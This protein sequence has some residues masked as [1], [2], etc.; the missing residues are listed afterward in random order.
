[1][2]PSFTCPLCGDTSFERLL[3]IRGATIPLTVVAFRCA[4]N[5]HIFFLRK[6]EFEATK[7]VAAHSD[8]RMRMWNQHRAVA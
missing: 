3:T 4:E 5:G 1:M 2:A 8:K 7:S 6:D